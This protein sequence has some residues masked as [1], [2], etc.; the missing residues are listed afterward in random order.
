MEFNQKKIRKYYS[1][2]GFRYIAG[3]AI[4]L[5]LILGIA[6]L[7]KKFFPE[8]LGSIQNILLVEMLPRFLIG[9]P[10]MVFIITRMPKAK[11]IE[12]H[13]MPTGKFFI[14]FIMAYALMLVINMAYTIPSSIIN[15]VMKGVGFKN[16]NPLANVVTGTNIFL[17]II[18]MVIIAPICE[19]LIFRKLLIDRAVKHGEGVAVVLSGV[20]FGL[21][22]GNLAQGLYA[23]GLGMFFGFIYVRTGRIRY[24]IFLHMIIN[25]L[26]S[27]IASL[28][29]KYSGISQ[30]LVSDDILGWFLENKS[31]VILYLAYSILVWGIVIAGVVLWIVFRRRFYLVPVEDNIP[32]G[33]RFSTVVINKGMIV[34]IAFW[35]GY[36]IFSFVRNMV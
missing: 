20:L 32:K 36:A 35:V 24:S 28:V 12:E 7:V 15:V 8:W 33:K 9:Y 21:F 19:E 17:Q 1:E 11:V 4:L 34:Y 2:L 16:I 27:V 5:L 31:G 13:K 30:L 18:L 6:F 25:F 23:T 22:H 10:I 29:L 26:G 14:A 3:S